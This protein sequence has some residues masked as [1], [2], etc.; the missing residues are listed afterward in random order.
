MIMICANIIY[1]LFCW[2]SVSSFYDFIIHTSSSI[3]KH[4]YIGQEYLTV[5]T[6]NFTYHLHVCIHLRNHL[7][8]ALL[9]LLLLVSLYWSLMREWRIIRHRN[10]ATNVSDATAAYEGNE[11]PEPQNSQQLSILLTMTILS[12]FMLYCNENKT[13]INKVNHGTLSNNK[14]KC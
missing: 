13:N 2:K 6:K 12:S 7:R 10:H 14:I 5:C 11:Y 9:L 8:R 4:G 1:W 3:F